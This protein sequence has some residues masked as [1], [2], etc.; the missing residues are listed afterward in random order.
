MLIAGIRLSLFSHRGHFL[1]RRRLVPSLVVSL[2]V[3]LIVS[4]PIT[5]LSLKNLFLVDFAILSS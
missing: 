4:L 2:V 3:S 5:L 1:L